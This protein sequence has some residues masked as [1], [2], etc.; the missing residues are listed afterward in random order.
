MEALIYPSE[1]Q[2][3]KTFK[4]LDP[5]DIL[6]L[7]VIGDFELKQEGLKKISISY[8]QA[9]DITKVYSLWDPHLPLLLIEPIQNLPV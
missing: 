2:Q 8:I 4:D 1:K 9:F 7:A 3:L 5:I 6:A